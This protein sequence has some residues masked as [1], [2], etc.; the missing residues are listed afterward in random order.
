MKVNQ[1]FSVDNSLAKLPSISIYTDTQE[2][3]NLTLPQSFWE[4]FLFF[5]ST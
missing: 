4:A 2:E 3:K 5:Q 1:T